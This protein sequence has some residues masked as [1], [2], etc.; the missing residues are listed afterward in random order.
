MR[1]VRGHKL[2]KG[3][4]SKGVYGIVGTSKDLM[5]RIALRKEVAEMY[6]DGEHRHLEEVFLTL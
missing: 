5:L 6:D 3:E 4:E 1:Y 2:Q